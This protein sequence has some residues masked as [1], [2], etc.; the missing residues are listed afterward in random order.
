MEEQRSSGGSRVTSRVQVCGHA[1]VLDRSGQRVPGRG[2][3]G[4][5]LDGI[6]L[7]VLEA[8]SVRILGSWNPPVYGGLALRRL[9]LLMA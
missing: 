3:S 9:V 2:I 1:V 4:G 7:Q 6:H 8:G 5:V